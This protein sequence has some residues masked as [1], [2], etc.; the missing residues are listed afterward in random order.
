MTDMMIPA[1]P[2]QP[3]LPHVARHDDLA[4]CLVNAYSREPMTV[5]ARFDVRSKHV[6]IWLR[7]AFLRHLRAVARRGVAITWTEERSLLSSTFDLRID[8]PTES[9]AIL[10]HL[11]R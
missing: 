8:G 1:L 10:E 4:H 7:A 9:H 5:I 11:C 3:T 6:P 2:L